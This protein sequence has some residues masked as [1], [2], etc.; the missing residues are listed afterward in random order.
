[1]RLVV[2]CPSSHKSSDTSSVFPRDLLD[3]EYQAN[4]NKPWLFEDENGIIQQFETE[5]EAC[6]AQRDWRLNNGFHPVKGTHLELD[7]KGLALT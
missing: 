3:E 7:A 2:D 4:F 5:E 6:A 1:M